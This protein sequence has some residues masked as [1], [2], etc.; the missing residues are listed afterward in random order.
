M[1]VCQNK[2]MAVGGCE[3]CTCGSVTEPK[4]GRVPWLL[5]ALVFMLGFALL[6]TQIFRGGGAKQGESLFD[7]TGIAVTETEGQP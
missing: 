5:I 7:K 2:G 3:N 4:P 1:S 6:F